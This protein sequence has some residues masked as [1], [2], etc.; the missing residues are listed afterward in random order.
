MKVAEA[1]L[2]LGT[3]IDLVDTTT[4]AALVAE[5]DSPFVKD[6]FTAAE[7]QYS[8]AGLSGR[9]AHYAAR[10]AAKEAC[11]K[12]LDAVY[13]FRAAPLT[14]VNY[15]EME[16]ARDPQGRPYLILQGAFEKIVKELNAKLFL[17]LA[18]DADKAIA[19][20]IVAC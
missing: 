12:A 17:S 2:I 13:L 6:H 14:R 7:R 4:F 18:H 10:Y 15:L 5:A 20:V 8:E 16:V 1:I 9:A 11:L 19:Q 3:G